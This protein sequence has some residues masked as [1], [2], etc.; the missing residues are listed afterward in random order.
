VARCAAAGEWEEIVVQLP[1]GVADQ[2]IV[3]SLQTTTFFPG[4]EDLLL[5]GQLRMLGVMVDAANV[6]Q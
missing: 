5:T 6:G 2:D 3:V 1:A 4:P